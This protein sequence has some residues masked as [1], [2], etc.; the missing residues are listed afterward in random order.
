M[1]NLIKQYE[2]LRK[3]MKAYQFANYLASWD[4]STEA[5]KGCFANRS[6][7][8]GVLSEEAYKLQTSEETSNI[9]D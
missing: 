4:A 1:E 7:Q 5:P 8:M 6:I 2:N 9:V 3:K